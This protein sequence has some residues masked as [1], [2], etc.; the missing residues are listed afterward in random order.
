MA[1]IVNFSINLDKIDKTKIINGAKGK[2][3]PLTVTLNN[4]VDQYGNQGPVII[5]QS[6]E[7]R[8]AKAE[9][10]Y[11]GNATVVWTDGINVDR[12][13]YEDQPAV[14]AAVAEEEDDLPF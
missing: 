13:P 1:S 9:K 11:L 12:A 5:A 3:L 6:K 10:V 7:D 2:Y 4:E 14:A 8:A